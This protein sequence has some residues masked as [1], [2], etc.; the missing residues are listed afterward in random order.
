MEDEVARLLIRS[1][2]G[3][4][5]PA[6]GAYRLPEGRL[7]AEETNALRVLAAHSS[8]MGQEEGYSPFSLARF[9]F[10][11]SGPAEEE[12]RICL[13]FGT[14]MS[15]SWA[16]G[17]D[18]N[19]TIPL[20]LGQPAGIGDT[21]AIPSAIFI[22]KSGRIYLGAAAETQHRQELEAGRKIFDN[23]KRM[24]SDAEIGQDLD[25]VLLTSAVD[26]TGSGLSRGDLL[27]LYL[28]WLTE[29]SLTA[30]EEQVKTAGLSFGGSSGEIRSVRRR[31]AIPCFEHALDETLGGG[32]KRAQ[33]AQ[34]TMERAVLRAQV[35]A[36]TLRGSWND[37]TVHRVREVL[38]ETR[39]LDIQG[40]SHLLAENPSVREPIAAGASR[41]E[42]Q[43][44]EGEGEGGTNGQS[45]RRLLLVVDS[46]AGTSDFAVFQVFRDPDRDQTRYA[47]IAPT[48]RMIR[49]A[50]NAVDEALRP[51]V[52]KACAID[53]ATGSPRSDDDFAL[54][55]TDLAAQIRD[56]KR[57]LFAQDS[58]DISFQ[59][60]AKGVLGL[61]TLLDDPSFKDLGGQLL[62]ARRSILGGLFDDAFLKHVRLA[63]E[64]FRRP[65]PIFVLLTG[66]SSGLPIVQDLAK[67]ELEIEGARFQFE[68]VKNLPE[69]VDQLPRE[70]AELVANAYP[71][72]AV[73]IGGSTPELPQEL[74]DLTTQITPP[75]PG[76]RQL[77]RYQV[78]GVG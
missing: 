57:D 15:K 36:D 66:G 28:A 11:H 17:R 3:R 50:G 61:E 74:P 65:M 70:V 2:I 14:A 35:V 44:T 76:E 10:D 75:P 49:I 9:A 30:L 8:T 69:W 60:N 48:V 21:L 18:V 54:I 73:A 40:L 62:D 12:I 1:L 13:D 19:T 78:T 31:F 52:L 67:G 4:L 41:F 77:P 29:M 32:K 43:L 24:L 39:G 37:L 46:G 33:W 58:V 27:V 47:L 56:I 34:Y 68:R 23:L 42:E 6:D 16:T 45:S 71:Q 53:P 22:S 7:S 38:A 55:K 20:V 25:H 59:P 72:C 64:R 63:N 26:P 51:L 5:I